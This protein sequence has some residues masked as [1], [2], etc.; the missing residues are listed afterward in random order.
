MK[1]ETD[2]L[3]KGEGAELVPAPELIPMLQPV[4]KGDYKIALVTS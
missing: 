1:A 4:I 3:V 2:A